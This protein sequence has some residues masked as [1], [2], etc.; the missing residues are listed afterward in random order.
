MADTFA[1]NYLRRLMDSPG[2]FTGTP[3]YQFAL[4]QG[5]QAINRRAAATGGRGSGNVLA[6]AAKYATGLATQDYGGSVERALRAAALE[7]EGNISGDRLGLDR[8]LGMG[9]LDL[10]RERLALDDRLGTGRLDLEGELGRGRLGL[11]GGRLDL[12]NRRAD[13]DFGLGWLRTSND[14]DLGR[15]GI[16]AGREGRFLDYDLGR[17]RLDLDGRRADNDFALGVGANDLGWYNAQTNRGRARMDY[18]LGQRGADNQAQ[19]NAYAGYGAMHGARNAADRNRLDRDRF[20][21]E[22]TL[23]PHWLRG[24]L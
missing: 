13:Q 19:A 11:E 7:Q 23:P 8:E 3:G 14:Y 20:E 17:G 21:F 6:E 15:R 24:A 22:R 5:T 16:D 12:D 9:Q 2:T 18:Q 10:G 1:K 4:D